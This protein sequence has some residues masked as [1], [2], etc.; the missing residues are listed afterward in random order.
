MVAHWLFM[1]FSKQVT[2][3]G[4]HLPLPGDL[5]DSG[6]QTWVSSLA[7]KFSTMQENKGIYQ[8][9]KENKQQPQ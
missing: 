8:K 4:Y 7:G 2:V 9:L 3:V 5:P 6:N 1:E